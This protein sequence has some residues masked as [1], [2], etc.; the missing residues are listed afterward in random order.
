MPTLPDVEEPPSPGERIGTALRRAGAAVGAD[1]RVS[2]RVLV[3][4]AALGIAAST[5]PFPAPQVAAV[6]LVILS[7]DWARTRL[8]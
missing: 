6:A 1:A 3:A 2:F 4:L 8:R 5:G 7:I